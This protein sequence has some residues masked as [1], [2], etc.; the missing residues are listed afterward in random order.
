VEF[1]LE[2]FDTIAVLCRMGSGYYLGGVF[3]CWYPACTS[4][5]EEAFLKQGM[6]SCVTTMIDSIPS[7]ILSLVLTDPLSPLSPLP[8]VAENEKTLF[9]TRGLT[10]PQLMFGLD[11]FQVSV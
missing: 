5:V 9:L 7:L 3:P 8:P 10:L 2:R 11:I 4:K 6:V 1:R